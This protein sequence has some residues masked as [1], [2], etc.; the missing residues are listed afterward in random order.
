[1]H[2]QLWAIGAECARLKWRCVW[3]LCFSVLVHTAGSQVFK[4]HRAARGDSGDR[5]SMGIRL[6]PIS[7]CRAL[8]RHRL[9][10]SLPE[11]LLL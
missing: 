11:Y 1:M 2:A 7:R 5:R 3:I 6:S 4:Q 9:A 10:P 8:R